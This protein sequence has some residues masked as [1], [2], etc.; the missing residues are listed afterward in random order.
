M[1]KIEEHL[2]NLGVSVLGSAITMYAAY[3]WKFRQLFVKYKF[4]NQKAAENF[5]IEDIENS[6]ELKVLAMCGSTF[7]DAINSPIANKALKDFELKQFYL[8]SN[9]NNPNIQKR[10]DELPKRGADGLK[11][12]VINSQNSFRVAMKNI[13]IECRL[14]DMKV[15]FRLI[16]L[17]NCL[18]LSQQEKGKFGKDTRIQRITCDKPEYINYLIYFDKLWKEYPLLQ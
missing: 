18:Y 3:W 6:K 17:D 12:K 11:T 7:S 1:C 2:I 5:I 10:Q 13:N 4:K 9:E 16:I 15:G 8:I 14:H